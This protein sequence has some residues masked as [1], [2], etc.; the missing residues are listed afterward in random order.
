MTKKPVLYIYERRELVILVFIAAVFSLMLFTVGIHYGVKVITSH[1]ERHA[2]ETAAV[3]TSDDA[4]PSRQELAEQAKKV[5]AEVEDAL[6][7]TVSEEVSRTGIR[8]DQARPVALPENTKSQKG[9]ATTLA[10]PKDSFYSLQI[11]SYSTKEEADQRAATLKNFDLSPFT[12][13]VEVPGKGKWY[14]VY[15][16]RFKSRGEAKQSGDKLVR[17]HVVESFV[18]ASVSDSPVADSAPSQ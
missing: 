14:R 10:P 1:P 11:G 3:D 8:L 18:V 7:K 12:R 6:D 15:L 4:L 16:G 9:G 13:E 5:G 2:Q 17:N